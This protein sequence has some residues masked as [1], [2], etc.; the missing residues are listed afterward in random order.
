MPRPVQHDCAKKLS[1]FVLVAGGC[2]QF[3]CTSEWFACRPEGP[4]SSIPLESS[5]PP[6]PILRRHLPDQ[7]DGFRRDLRRMRDSL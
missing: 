3:S 1:T 6:E 5:Q 4:V 2:E 7:G